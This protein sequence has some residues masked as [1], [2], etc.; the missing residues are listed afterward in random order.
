MN[1][2]IYNA[3]AQSLTESRK[4]KALRFHCRYS[5]PIREIRVHPWLSLPLR[6]WSA[7]CAFALKLSRLQFGLPIEGD[8]GR[9]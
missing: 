7:L 1:P 9:A 5:F 6:L 3:K 8:G 2:K 4:D